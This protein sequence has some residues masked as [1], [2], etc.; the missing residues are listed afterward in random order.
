MSQSK[1]PL[2]D[3]KAQYETIKD[4]LAVAVSGVLESQRFILGPEVEALEH[5]IADYCQ[6]AH[7][8]G[9]SSGSDALLISL[10]ALDI[11]AG[12]EVITSPYTFF[13]TGGA[14]A[15]VGAK[16]VFVDIDPQTFNIA[17]QQIED[18]ITPRTKAIVPVHLYGQCAEMEPIN[19]IAARHGLAVIED[20]AQALGAEYQGRRAG[21]LGTVGCFSFFP[22]K[23]LG[24]C[25][26]GGAVTTNDGQLADKIRCMRVH[27]SKPKYFHKIIGGNFRLDA[28]QA[29]VLRVKLKYLDRWT[30]DRQR[31]AANYAK[32]FAAK[33]LDGALATTPQPVQ[34]RHVFNQYIVRLS[35]RDRVQAYL[36]E[37]GI[38]CEI[39]Y[40]V[41]LHLQDCFADLGYQTGDLPRSEAAANSTLALPVYPELSP[42]AQQR[43]VDEIDR[44]YEALGKNT[45]LRHAA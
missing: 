39:Y 40:P 6:A 12:D 10:M 13:A 27:G 43:V 30:A 9:V 28:L 31:N 38:G 44:C 32:L 33:G 22:S 29:A 37:Q 16:V 23:N 2:L 18:R 3:L 11:G 34:D 35:D 5:E 26:D 15:R 14:I 36:K 7:C 45:T 19:A 41:P 24:A 20:A 17:P 25:G 42:A 4:E 21:S 8:I 1:I